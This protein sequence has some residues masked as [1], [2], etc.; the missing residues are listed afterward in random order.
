MKFRRHSCRRALL[1]GLN[2]RC[3]SRENG[4]LLRGYQNRYCERLKVL[5]H[6]WLKSLKTCHTVA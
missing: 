6:G 1:H 4:A 2:F 3:H 5:L